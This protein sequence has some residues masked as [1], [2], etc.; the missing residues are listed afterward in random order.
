MILDKDIA[1]LFLS[2]GLIAISPMLAILSNRVSKYLLDRYVADEVLVI[3]YKSCGRT[4]S[5]VIIKTKSDGSTA[6]K[7]TSLG[8]M[9]S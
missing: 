5:R 9:E 1:W 2:I 8:G 4:T 6:A 7:I 3:T